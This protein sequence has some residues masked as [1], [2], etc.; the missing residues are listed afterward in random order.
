MRNYDDDAVDAVG[1]EIIIN[2]INRNMHYYLQTKYI[3]V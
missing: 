3:Y 1:I 2:K